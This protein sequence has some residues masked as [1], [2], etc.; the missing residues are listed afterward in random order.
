M[1]LHASPEALPAAPQSASAVSARRVAVQVRRPRGSEREDGVEQDRE[2]LGR[3]V[4]AVRVELVDEVDRLDVQAEGV[5]EEPGETGTDAA[6][7]A[8]LLSESISARA[9]LDARDRQ[10]DRNRSVDLGAPVERKAQ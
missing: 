4:A 7:P 1:F 2:L 10:T 6:V 9:I 3:G 8:K 5:A